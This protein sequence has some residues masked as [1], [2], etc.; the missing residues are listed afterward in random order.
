MVTL[1]LVKNNLMKSSGCLRGCPDGL[2]TRD[3]Q[4]KDRSVERIESAPPMPCCY[5]HLKGLEPLH[6]RFDCFR[7]CIT[8]Q[9]IHFFP[10]IKPYI[11]KNRST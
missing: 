8:A 7:I 2:R 11:N 1:E 9:S 10:E 5:K 6:T 4:E 3:A